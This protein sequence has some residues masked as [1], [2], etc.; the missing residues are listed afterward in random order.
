MSKTIVSRLI[1]YG[2]AM[3][4]GKTSSLIGIHYAY[5]SAGFNILL[6]KPKID[7]KGDSKVE[8]RNKQCL[9]TDFLISDNDNIADIIWEKYPDADVIIIDEVQFLKRHHIDEL[10][11]L[12]YKENKLVIC[13]GLL[14]DFQE[15]MFDAS[16]RLIE[17]GAELKRLTIPCMCG[18]DRTHNLRMVNGVATFD[19]EQI[20]IDGASDVIEYV[21]MCGACYGKHKSRALRRY[22]SNQ[23]VLD[24]FKN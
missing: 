6:G 13:Y 5:K 22:D 24:E 15:K 11:E 18:R 12:V 8:A 21:P 4:V 10:A 3:G 19:G 16:M 1:F 20:E 23:V 17:V 14:T 9:E 2:G 7:S